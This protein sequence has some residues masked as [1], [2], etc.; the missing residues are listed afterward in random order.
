MIC[1]LEKV[2]IQLFEVQIR[3][4]A[5]E[6]LNQ[7]FRPPSNSSYRLFWGLFGTAMWPLGPHQSPTMLV[8]SVGLGMIALD[9]TFL[10]HCS[11]TTT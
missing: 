7:G 1:S 6:G 4:V 11:V 9:L 10:W 2:E 5:W 8:F 3:G